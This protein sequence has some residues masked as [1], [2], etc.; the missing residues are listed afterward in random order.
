MKAF[1]EMA[2]FPEVKAHLA[3]QQCTVEASHL[4][5]AANRAMAELCAR[6]GIKGRRITTVKLTLSFV[7]RGCSDSHPDVTRAPDV[8]ATARKSSG[9]GGRP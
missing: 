7:P 9:R 4:A 1:V 3:W 2:F 8:R 5:C 6:D